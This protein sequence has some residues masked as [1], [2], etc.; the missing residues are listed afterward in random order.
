LSSAVL[1]PD[2]EIHIHF[3]GGQRQRFLL[4][5][6][7]IKQYNPEMTIVLPKERFDLCPDNLNLPIR[8]VRDR[9]ELKTED[10]NSC[11]NRTPKLRRKRKKYREAPS[12]H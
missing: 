5:L 8:I 12:L 7:L 2:V 9:I 3:S 11:L 6:A 4:A 1:I 10:V